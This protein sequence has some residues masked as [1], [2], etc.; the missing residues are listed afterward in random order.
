MPGGA[1][2]WGRRRSSD[3]SDAPLPS[4]EDFELY[5]VGHNSL[6]YGLAEHGFIRFEIVLI[7]QHWWRREPK[8]SLRNRSDCG[9]GRQFEMQQARSS[10]AGIWTTSRRCS[11]ACPARTLA[12][13]RW[14][15]TPAV[16]FQPGGEIARSTSMKTPYCILNDRGLTT[17]SNSGT[18]R[19]DCP[20]R[21]SAPTSIGAGSAGAE[22]SAG[23]RGYLVVR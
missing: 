14:R 11:S 15:W 8:L 13:C 1:G 18:M 19:I 5:V 16:Q 20:P 7:H 12:R 2:A 6:G 21:P 4:Y 22:P 23:I 9:H 10:F 3:I 17:R